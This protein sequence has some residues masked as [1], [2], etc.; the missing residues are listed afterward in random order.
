MRL[1][2]KY[3]PVILSDCVGEAAKTVKQLLVGGECPHLLLWG[4]PG[5]GK[6]TL[7]HCIA[8]ELL[9]ERKQLNCIEVN[10]SEERGIDVVRSKILKFAQLV[11]VGVGKKVIILD[12]ADSITFQAQQALRRP[13]ETAEKSCTF[14][15]TA[16][17]REKIHDAIASRCTDI[18]V[19]LTE[20][21]VF[22][23]FRQVCDSEGYKFNSDVVKDL[24]EYYGLDLRKLLDQYQLFNVTG[25]YEKPD[26]M[27]PL[28]LLEGGNWREASKVLSSDMFAPMYSYL[29]RTLKDT[30]LLA[31]L[32]GVFALYDWRLNSFSCNPMIQL[33]A[34]AAEI[35]S[36]LK[37]TR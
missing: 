7:A 32:A 5:T 8:N 34:F 21:F 18:Q 27:K 36:L 10:A 33:S 23:R 11:P 9:G 15:F 25:G 17:N 14:I 16:N 12:E 37:S 19:V 4:T 31:Q 35:V 13:M 22:E 30:V 29:C 1:S 3:R 2:E 28:E 6:T 24:T 26:F 20:D